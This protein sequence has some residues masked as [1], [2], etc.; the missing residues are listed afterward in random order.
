MSEII[1]RQLAGLYQELVGRQS[2]SKVAGVGL[3]NAEASGRAERLLICQCDGEDLELRS[4][5]SHFWI[6]DEA[7]FNPGRKWPLTTEIVNQ[8][9]WE[10]RFPFIKFA[11]DGRCIRFG[12]RFGPSW[13]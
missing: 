13:Y 3:S 4:T 9:D 2:F 5:F 8:E 6:V 10:T 7:G 11:T 12:M 1:A